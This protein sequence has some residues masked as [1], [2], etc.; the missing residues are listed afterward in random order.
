[1]PLLLVRHAS[2]GSR[3]EWAGDDRARP[4][5]ERGEEQAR[6]LVA[7]LAD[8]PVERILTSPYLRCVQTVQPIAADRQLAVEERDELGEARQFDAG[9]RLVTSLAGS[10]VLV[11]GH[12]GLESALVD[13]PRWKKAA[14][15]VVSDDLTVDELRRP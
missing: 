10:D 4:L 5:D 12:G 2:A 8:L 11:C 7:L 9:A 1:M 15:F 6:R 3:E 13:A 14:V